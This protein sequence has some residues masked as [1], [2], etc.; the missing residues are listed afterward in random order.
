MSGLRDACLC[1]TRWSFFIIQRRDVTTGMSIK[2]WAEG[3]GGEGWR[4]DVGQ[5]QLQV[6]KPPTDRS[7]HAHHVKKRAEKRNRQR[8]ERCGRVNG[9]RQMLLL[10]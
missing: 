7:L 8:N 5:A 1:S 4:T 10:L 9:D 2:Q 6:V 3:G